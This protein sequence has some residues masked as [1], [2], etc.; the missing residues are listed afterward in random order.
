MP[1]S[2]VMPMADDH[3]RPM[4]SPTLAIRRHRFAVASIVLLLT[5]AV[6]GFVISIPSRYDAIASVVVQ[7]RPGALNNMQAVAKDRDIDPNLIGTEVDILR[8]PEMARRVAEKLRLADNSEFGRQVQSYPGWFSQITHLLGNS[9]PPAADGTAA[10]DN[11]L[12]A[13]TI[14]KIPDQCASDRR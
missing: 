2:L 14:I 12:K 5:A 7:T 13:I 8:S 1:M 11:L 9:L 3:D 6:A 10:I 4:F